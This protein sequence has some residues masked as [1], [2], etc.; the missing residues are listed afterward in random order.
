MES[1]FSE[2]TLNPLRHNDSYKCWILG[3]NTDIDEVIV[4]LKRIM[5][6]YYDIHGV[7]IKIDDF[8]LKISIIAEHDSI[9]NWKSKILNDILLGEYRNDSA[10]LGQVFKVKLNVYLEV[11]TRFNHD[12]GIMNEENIDDTKR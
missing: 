11:G 9:E 7:S 6:D 12:Y 8:N 10:I 4:F 1:V 2:V 3:Y 5:V